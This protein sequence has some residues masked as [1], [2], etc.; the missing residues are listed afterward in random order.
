MNIWTM[1]DRRDIC[2]PRVYLHAYVVTQCVFFAGKG[3][4][5]W[6]EHSKVWMNLSLEEKWNLKF[7]RKKCVA[8]T[9]RHWRYFNDF[10][11]SLPALDTA[12]GSR[13]TLSLSIEVLRSLERQQSIY[14]FLSSY[15]PVLSL[16]RW[17]YQRT[18]HNVLPQPLP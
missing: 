14:H 10:Y 17:L 16:S 6:S 9:G 4:C 8:P 12:F 15:R 18:V 1:G 7:Y 5:N 11:T 2:I 3:R 13:E